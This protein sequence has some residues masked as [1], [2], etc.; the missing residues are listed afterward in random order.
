MDEY[1]HFRFIVIP[2]LSVGYDNRP[3]DDV[4]TEPPAATSEPMLE[5]F[6]KLSPFLSNIT[7]DEGL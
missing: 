5:K 7:E 2:M 1:G 6:S 3:N 4:K